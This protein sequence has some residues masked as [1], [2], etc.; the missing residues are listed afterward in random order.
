MDSAFAGL[1]IDDHYLVDQGGTFQFA[2]RNN[3]PVDADFEL[4]LTGDPVNSVAPV[5]FELMPGESQTITVSIRDSVHSGEDPVT[6]DIDGMITAEWEKGEIT[7]GFGL[8]VSVNPVPVEPS[9][10][11]VQEGEKTE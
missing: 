7:A 3:L 10:E 6:Y 9:P 5:D 11:S 4:Q 2:V 8:Q 1:Q